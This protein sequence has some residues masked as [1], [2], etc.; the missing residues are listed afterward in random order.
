MSKLHLEKL[1]KGEQS[2][3]NAR[4][5]GDTEELSRKNKMQR[6]KTRDRTNEIKGCPLKNR[7]TIGQP[8]AKL[9]EIK[10]GKIKLLVSEM[11]Q[12]LKLLIKQ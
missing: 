4:G 8:L 12:I 2:E 10:R 11:K 5:R 7:N 6:R 1:E 9:T 3:P